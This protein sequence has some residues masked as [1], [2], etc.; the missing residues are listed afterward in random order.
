[1]S[2]S[3]AATASLNSGS[4][5]DAG[6]DLPECLLISG[7]LEAVL[8]NERIK[9]LLGQMT[10][11]PVAVLCH[12]PS[13]ELA[14]QAMRQGCGEILIADQA[15]EQLAVALQR[16][17]TQHHATASA[18]SERLVLRE[19]MTLLTAAEHDVLDAMLDGLANKQIAQALQIGLRTVELRRSK[20]MKKMGA[21]SLAQLVKF[22]CIAQG[23]GHSVAPT[24]NGQLTT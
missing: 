22:I 21:K 24:S 6:N 9:A 8:E 4:E 13:V 17:V 12:R 2:G 10:G 16:F 23:I 18:A 1:M 3:M 14:I 5:A 7:P 11:L 20:I 19:R 15:T